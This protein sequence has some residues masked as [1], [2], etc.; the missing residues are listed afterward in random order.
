M[1][2]SRKKLRDRG[3]VG[4]KGKLRGGSWVGVRE[5]RIINFTAIRY[6]RSESEDDRELAYHKYNVGILSTSKERCRNAQEK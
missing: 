1:G 6:A 2:N 3:G 4:K 5:G